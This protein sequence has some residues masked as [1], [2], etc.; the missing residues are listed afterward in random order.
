MRKDEFSSLFPLPC[1]LWTFYSCTFG[2]V[3]VTILRGVPQYYLGNPHPQFSYYLV[4]QSLVYSA[5]HRVNQCWWH[6]QEEPLVTRLTVQPVSGGCALSGPT[7]LLE[8]SEVNSA[9]V[10]KDKLCVCL[11]LV[12]WRGEDG[13]ERG[14]SVLILRTA[15]S[16]DWRQNHNRSKQVNAAKITSEWI[17][18][19]GGGGNLERGPERYK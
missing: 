15:V 10:P 2:P 7:R 13:A 17:L 8:V 18:V 4:P 14:E 12:V 6:S 19:T 16:V 3:A 1:A 9:L 5:G 11:L